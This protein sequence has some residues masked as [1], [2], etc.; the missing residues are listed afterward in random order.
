MPQTIGA[1]RRKS[2]LTAD[3]RVLPP[4]GFDGMNSAP[5]TVYSDSVVTT[6][7][8]ANGQTWLRRHQKQQLLAGC[9]LAG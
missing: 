4:G 3:Y 6:A 2:R 1:W 5:S 8:V 9:R 7:A